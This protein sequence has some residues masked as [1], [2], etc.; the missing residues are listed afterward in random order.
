MS[1]RWAWA[2][3]LWWASGVWAG[4]VEAAATPGLAQI[5]FSLPRAATTSAGVYATDGR[6]LRT[7]WRGEPLTAGSHQRSWDGLDDSGQPVPSGEYEVKLIHHH[8]RYVWEGVIGNSSATVSDDQVHRAY[9]P[10]TSI[11]ISGRKAIYAVGFNEQQDGLHG[12][13]LTTPERDTRPF[14]SKDTFVSYAMVAVDATRLYWANVGGLIRTNFVGAFDLQS[15][16]PSAFAAGVPICL[17]RRPNSTAC[18]EQQQ[19]RGVIDLHTEPSEAPTGIAVQ[20]QGRVLAV[21]HGMRDVIR[22]FDKHSGEL[23]Q[24]M[25]VPLAGKALNQIA[26]SADGDLWLI[27]GDTVLRYTDLDHVP[28]Q[29][30]TL[31]GLTRP[32]ALAAHPTDSGVLWVAEGGAR[33]QLRRFDPQGRPDFV[34]GRIGGYGT[35]PEVQPDKLCFKTRE[36]REQTSMAVGPEQTLWVIDTC[37]NRMLRFRTSDA[38][39][40][41]GTARSDAQVA[42]LPG[43][44]TSTVDHGAPHRVFANFLEFEAP[45]RTPWGAGRPWKLVRNWLGGLPLTLADQYAFNAAFGGLLSVET[46]A[47]G[48]TYGLMMV[49]RRQVIV[50]LPATGPLRVVRAFGAP[51]PGTTYKVLY[52]NGDLGYALTGPRTQTSMR[53]PRAGFDAAGDPVWSNEPLVLASVPTLDGTPYFRGGAMGMPPRFPLTGSGKVIFF[54]S[55]IRGNEGFHLGAAERGGQRWLWQASPTAALDG[56]GSY[57]TKAIDASLQYGGNAVWAHGRHVVYGYH[58]EF[59]KDMRSGQVGQASQFM[60]FD[61]SGLFIGQFGTSIVPPTA[62]VQP[63]MSGN[64][65]SPTLVRID[66]QLYLYHNDESA[67]AGVHR[68]RLEGWNDVRDLSGRGQRGGTIVLR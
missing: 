53:L 15:A 62:P 52:E 51:L 13:D 4:P 21:A 12:F 57:Q 18:Y 8:M 63:G 40:A 27:S 41:Q 65:F 56:K 49:N 48:R 31:S 14:P 37:N 17:N 68:W 25:T 35:D 59:Y 33:Q 55:S 61:E 2:A 29:V 19:Y 34:I 60:H 38:T 66:D 28:R 47:N 20:A 42:Y 36:G 23:L 6:L 1:V 32:L 11:V 39:L 44:Y 3:A 26:M 46:F 58:G 16:Q 30:A 45:T 67:H 10:P 22:L 64:A 7:L 50:E 24:E 9:L 43:V 5:S 54:D